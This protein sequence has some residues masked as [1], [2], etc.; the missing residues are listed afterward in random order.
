MSLDWCYV[1]LWYRVQEVLYGEVNE[2]SACIVQVWSR[3]VL[4]VNTVRGGI[5]FRSNPSDSQSDGE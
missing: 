3:R 4:H 5:K 1:S 2:Q